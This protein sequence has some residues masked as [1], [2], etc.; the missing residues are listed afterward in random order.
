MNCSEMSTGVSIM[1]AVQFLHHA[2]G[3]VCS[4]ADVSLIHRVS[5]HL[6][7]NWAWTW[8]SLTMQD[9]AH[10]PLCLIKASICVFLVVFV[11]SVC[12]QQPGGSVE[13]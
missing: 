13:S 4:R 6:L 12:S 8:F 5:H 9:I 11:L 10:R 1:A 2:A 7:S 3:S